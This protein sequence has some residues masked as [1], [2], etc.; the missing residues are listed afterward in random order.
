MRGVLLFYIAWILVG[1]CSAQELGLPIRA[2]NAE[3]VAFFETEIRPVLVQHCYGCHGPDKQ[4]GGLRLDNLPSI[5]EGGES[6]PAIEL[7]SPEQSLLVQAIRYE[8]LQMPPSGK[9]PASKIDAFVRWISADAP[10]SD[11]FV[12][13]VMEG[14]GGDAKEHSS[15]H[16]S[17]DEI[18]EADRSHWSLLPIQRREPAIQESSETHPIDAWISEGLAREELVPSP[19]AD[20]RELLRRVSYTLTGLPLTY[21]EMESWVEKLAIAES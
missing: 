6:G 15:K 14:S 3:Q 8:S 7:G 9:L 19:R 17:S 13:G 21:E 18:T 16:R 10:V 12:K 20:V 1:R 5:L 4:K 11:D 2:A